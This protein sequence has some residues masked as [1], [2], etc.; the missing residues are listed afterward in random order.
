MVDEDEDTW[1]TALGWFGLHHLAYTLVPTVILPGRLYC[2]A[3]LFTKGEHG[4]LD[5]SNGARI[6]IQVVRYVLLAALSCE[7]RIQI[8]SLGDIY[9]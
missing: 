2:E 4:A 8:M 9:S 7:H 5:E 1:H 6:H 3:I